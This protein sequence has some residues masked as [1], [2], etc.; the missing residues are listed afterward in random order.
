M[1]AVL[2]I[3][4]EVAFL[5]LFSEFMKMKHPE[6]ELYCA[7]SGKE[8]IELYRRLHDEGKTPS[9]VL[10]DYHMSGIEGVDTISEIKKIDEEQRV[11]M[12]TADRASN[13]IENAKRAGALMV[14]EK[15]Y[16]FSEMVERVTKLLHT[17]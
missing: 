11:V 15:L 5:E 9:V 2:L 4:D 6:V 16:D 13:H 1:N 3:D 10:V 8:G 7:S 12:L 17:P 14:M